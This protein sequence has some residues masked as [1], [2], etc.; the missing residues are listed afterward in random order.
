MAYQ[1]LSPYQNESNHMKKETK[2]EL[3]SL[4]LFLVAVICVVA[5]LYI[6]TKMLSNMSGSDSGDT[7]SQARTSTIEYNGETYYYNYNLKNILF[8][9][10]DKGEE[11]EYYSMTGQAGQADCIMILSIDSSTNEARVLQISR[12][13]MTDI[14]LYATNGRKYSTITGQ[15]TLQ[16]GYGLG[17]EQSCQAMKKKVGEI[18]EGVTI[19]GYFSLDID[20]VPIINDKLGGVTIT[21][22]EDFTDVDESYVEGATVTLDGEAAEHFVR[23]RDMSK[24]GGNNERMRRQVIYITALFDA[25]NE[26]SSSVE[27]FYDLVKPLIS[28][29]MVTDLTADEIS[30]LA[31]ANFLSEETEY[32]PGEVIQGE[33][34]DEFYIDEDALEALIVEF[35]YEKK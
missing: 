26:K 34:H 23:Y 10:I 30:E 14:D 31:S 32:V 18:L 1:R 15:L 35:F 16:Y 11:A 27:A 22:T 6:I 4:V 19:N 21:F 8:M 12:D 2:K 17:A 13:S 33:E 9:G 5:A 7:S 25:I 29:Y 24:S 20:A 3:R 28:S